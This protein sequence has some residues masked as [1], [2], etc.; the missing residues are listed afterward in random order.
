MVRRVYNG[1]VQ[2]RFDRL[3]GRLNSVYKAYIH[4]YTTGLVRRWHKQK[5]ATNLKSA[6]FDDYDK[7]SIQM[8]RICRNLLIF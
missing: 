2:W 4:N 8:Y 1:L 5:V 7:Q 6:A 3:Q